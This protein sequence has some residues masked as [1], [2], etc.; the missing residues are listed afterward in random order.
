MTLDEA[1]VLMNQK[2]DEL[3]PLL[4][5]SGIKVTRETGFLNSLFMTAKNPKRAKFATVTL[6]L[7]AEGVEEEN[8][9]CISLTA[10][11][12][13]GKVN[14]EKLA[15][16]F[17]EFEKY[18]KETAERLNAEGDATKTVLALSKEANAEYEKLLAELENARKKS[19][20]ISAIG[21]VLVVVGIMILFAVALMM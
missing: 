18:V 6:T 10:E 1:L 4:D 21:T 14:E 16:S 5:I 3:L 17:S 8:E 2:V 12:K 15:L 19:Q 11:V 20:K 9:Y 7:S 13:F